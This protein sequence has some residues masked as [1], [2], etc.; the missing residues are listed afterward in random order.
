MLFIPIFYVVR[1]Y[2]VRVKGNKYLAKLNDSSKM[3][4]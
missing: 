1:V 2:V 3:P 4:S